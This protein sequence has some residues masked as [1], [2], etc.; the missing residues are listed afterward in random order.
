VDGAHG[1]G[2]GGD[3]GDLVWRMTLAQLQEWVARFSYKPDHTFAVVERAGGRVSIDVI[4]S[5]LKDASGTYTDPKYTLELHYHKEFWMY[6]LTTEAELIDAMI[7]LCQSYER[8]EMFEWL[9][10]DGKQVRTPH[11][12]PQSETP[13]S[14]A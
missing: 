14:R 8:H 1:R 7:Q 5:K 4:A 3:D 2:T 10:L 11:V 6:D 12:I 9:K 13:A